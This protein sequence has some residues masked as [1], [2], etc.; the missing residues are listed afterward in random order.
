M[1]ILRHQRQWDI[2]KANMGGGADG[3]VLVLSSDET[4]R[5]LDS[6]LLLCEV[7]PESLQRLTAGPVAVRIDPKERGLSEP[8]VIDVPSMASAPRNCLVSLEGRLE[9]VPLRVAV[10]SAVEVLVG[11]ARWP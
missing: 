7:V 5:I 3:L 1:A 10:L 6:G 2:Y 11:L 9:S 8:A 4:N